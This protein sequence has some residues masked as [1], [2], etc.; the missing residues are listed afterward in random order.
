M[1]WLLYARY[2]FQSLWQSC[3]GVYQF[4]G[5]AATKDHELGGLKQE[6][7]ILSQLWRPEVQSQGVGRAALH[8]AALGE[9]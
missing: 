7:F 4:P 6:K 5:A 9:R 2:L 1:C 3:E 8:P